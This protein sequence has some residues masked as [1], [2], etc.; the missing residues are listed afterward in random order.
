MSYTTASECFMENRTIVHPPN[1]NQ[2]REIIWNLNNGL[3]ELTQAV[4]NYLGQI[5]F[6]LQEILQTLQH[7]KAH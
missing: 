1:K 3:V 7:Q 4:Q 5:R 2:D 6:L